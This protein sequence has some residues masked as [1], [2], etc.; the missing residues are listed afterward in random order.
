MFEP[1]DR[2]FGL[3]EDFVGK[4]SVELGG[5]RVEPGTQRSPPI[6]IELDQAIVQLRCDNLQL[7][8]DR[9][10]TA[11]G[12]FFVDAP[13]VL[14]RGWN[15]PTWIGKFVL[16]GSQFGLIIAVKCRGDLTRQFLQP[17]FFPD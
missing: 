15:Y 5:Q 10:A 17:S 14:G 8:K 7:V 4:V 3:L 13:E 6:G 11:S 12:N 2:R 1:L 9:F 16:K